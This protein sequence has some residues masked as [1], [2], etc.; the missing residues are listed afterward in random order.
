MSINGMVGIIVP[1][2]TYS[3]GLTT[4]DREIT[5]EFLFAVMSR[6]LSLERVEAYVSLQVL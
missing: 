1:L 4:K 2:K 5:F 6:M 3:S